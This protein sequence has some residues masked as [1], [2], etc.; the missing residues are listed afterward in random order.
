MGIGMK[1]LLV[2]LAIALLVFGAKKLKTIG[3]D[4]GGAVRGFK[5]AMSDGE[6]EEKKKEENMKQIR[7]DA[8]DAEF[9]EAAKTD[10]SKAKKEDSKV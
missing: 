3:T 2:I 6:E 7:S 5:K 4:L 8:P 9:A 10:A 1:E